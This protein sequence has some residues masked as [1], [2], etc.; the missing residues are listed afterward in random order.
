[1]FCVRSLHSI[2]LSS[3][4]QQ[5]D[6]SSFW[7]SATNE[8]GK[9]RHSSGCQERKVWCWM[10]SVT[11]LEPPNS[12]LEPPN[13]P[14]WTQLLRDKDPCDMLPVISLFF[15]QKYSG[16]FQ[17]KEASVVRNVIRLPIE[18]L[19]HI[20]LGTDLCFVSSVQVFSCTTFNN[21]IT[22]CSFCVLPCLVLTMRA[23]WICSSCQLPL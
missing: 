13:S 19:K 2:S 15:R 14:L 12:A 1:M 23:G 3:W 5:D 6:E 11:A 18:H 4:Q 16:E 21:V 20:S 9:N 10:G 8:I 22:H 7:P 17:R